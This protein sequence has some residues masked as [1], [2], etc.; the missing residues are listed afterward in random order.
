MRPPLYPGLAR[1][2]QAYLHEDFTL[3]PGSWQ[4]AV[5]QF[6]ILESP[7]VVAQA[8]AETAALMHRRLSDKELS[9]LFKA[10]GSRY[11]PAGDGT[12]FGIWV[13]DLATALQG[14]PGPDT[15]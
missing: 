5:Q 7:A 8:R 2:C 6:L 10:I 14:T 3:D 15:A 12:S 1:L 4:A 11:W 9:D 13:R